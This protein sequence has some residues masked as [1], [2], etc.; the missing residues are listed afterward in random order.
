MAGWLAGLGASKQ[1]GRPGQ[2]ACPPLCCMPLQV[3]SA[4]LRH[5]YMHNLKNRCDIC[6]TPTRNDR[7]YFVQTP[8]RK[9]D[10]KNRRTHFAAERSDF[11]VSILDVSLIPTS[12]S[13][14]GIKSQAYSMSKPPASTSSFRSGPMSK[15][16]CQLQ[17]ACQPASLASS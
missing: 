3:S 11:I 15:S 6:T 17:P 7:V 4:A 9:L 12:K 5:I 14:E 10:T 1:S 13:S 8:C 16:A 2:P